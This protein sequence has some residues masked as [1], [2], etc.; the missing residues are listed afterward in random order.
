MFAIVRVE[1]EVT[2]CDDVRMVLLTAAVSGSVAL[3][4]VWLG[5]RWERDSSNRAWWRERRLAV[6]SEFIS[7]AHD[8]ASYAGVAAARMPLDPSAPTALPCGGADRAEVTRRLERESI[9]SYSITPDDALDAHTKLLAVNERWVMVNLLGPDSVTKKA[10]DVNEAAFNLVEA[11]QEF[12]QEESLVA[13]NA[14]VRAEI[15]FTEAVGLAIRE[16]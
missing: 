16:T 5:K 8:L 1:W 6:C 2:V 15:E 3:I 13:V 12:G 7:A 14:L 11:L 4:G 10:S 9:R